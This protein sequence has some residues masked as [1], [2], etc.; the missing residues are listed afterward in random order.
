MI[1]CR[2]ASAATVTVP[3]AVSR[4]EHQGYRP[5]DRSSEVE[6]LRGLILRF[7]WNEE[8]DIASPKSGPHFLA[9]AAGK[10]PFMKADLVQIL[11]VPNLP[12]AYIIR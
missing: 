4:D 11:R 5:H 10:D 7:G 1:D 12:Q 8:S 2:F 6:V 3:Q 9:E